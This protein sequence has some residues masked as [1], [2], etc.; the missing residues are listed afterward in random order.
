MRRSP[1]WT[2]GATSQIARARKSAKKAK[3]NPVEDDYIYDPHAKPA[4]RKSARKGHSH[5]RHHRHR[6]A[7]RGSQ[8]CRR[9][10]RPR[11]IRAR[12]RRQRSH[13]FEIP[14]RRDIGERQ[15]NPLPG[16]R[17]RSE[18]RQTVRTRT[19]DAVDRRAIADQT[20]EILRLRLEVKG[21]KGSLAVMARNVGFA[22]I[23]DGRAAVLK[24]AALC[25]GIGAL[26]RRTGVSRS[27][28]QNVASGNK[29]PTLRIAVNVRAVIEAETPSEPVIEEAD[30]VVDAGYQ[31]A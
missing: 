18:A 22:E 29:P 23:A 28:L 6:T 3:P 27:H 17:I 19:Q 2:R 13:R 1:A 14:R 31:A 30:N 7:R 10:R 25:G 5:A 20:A 12:R 26:A 4:R 16:L 15:E 24:A 11:S 9:T 21:L 8:G